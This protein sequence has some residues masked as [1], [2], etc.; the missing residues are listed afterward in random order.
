M[1]IPVGEQM[2]WPMPCDLEWTLR[3]GVPSMSERYRAASIVAAY[4]ELIECT[5]AKRRKVIRVLRKALREG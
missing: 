1:Y 2:I 3:Y 4:T 5:E